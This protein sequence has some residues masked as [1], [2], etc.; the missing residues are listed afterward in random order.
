VVTGKVSDALR[1]LRFA[2]IATARQISRMRI[3]AT[4]IAV[5]ILVAVAV[6]APMPTAVDLRDWS[7]SAGPW[8]PLAFLAA[9][10]VVT[11]FPFPRTAF[12]LAAGLLFGTVLGVGL[13]VLAST[14][15]ALIALWLVRAVGWQLDRLVSHSAIETVDA[16]LSRRGWRVVV[17]MR[18]I[19]VVPFSVVNYAAGASAV[20]ALP[21]TLAT[22]VGLIPGTLAVVVLGD[23]LTGHISPLLFLVSLCTA[24]IGVIGLAFEFRAHRRERREVTGSATRA[25]DPTVP[26]VVATAADTASAGA[27]G[28]E[29]RR[30]RPRHSIAHLLPRRPRPGQSRDRSGY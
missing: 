27:V 21:Y 9:H 25:A 5:V 11:V 7:K 16:R 13:A 4:V 10:L 12:T 17:L 15:S 26:A 29:L 8:F 14:L 2:I 20:R 1:G 18:L 3:V 6:L 23:A 22:F 24:S 19:P 30:S 28:R